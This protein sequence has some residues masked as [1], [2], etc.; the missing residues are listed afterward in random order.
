MRTSSTKGFTLIELLVVVVVIGILAAVAIPKFTNSKDRAARS[1]AFADL[2]NLTTAQ[3]N[4]YA[5]SNRYGALADTTL[6]RFQP[7]RGNTA[8]A[9]EATG[10]S[11]NGMIQIPGGKKC[12][13]KFG[14][15][16]PAPSGWT[17]PALVDGVAVCEQ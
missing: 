16:A 17:G 14:A 13:V 11:W 12:A 3:E 4:F 1:A 7:S 15:A 5:D 10:Q 2:R 6:M 9:I 8:L